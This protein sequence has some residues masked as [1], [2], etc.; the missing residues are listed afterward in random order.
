MRRTAQLLA[1]LMVVPLWARA[2]DAPS[3]A[4]NP[5]VS[6]SVGLHYGGPLRTSVALGLLIDTNE[7]R[8]ESIEVAS[9]IGQQ[10]Y[11]LFVGMLKMQ[12]Q[13]GSGYAVHAT[14][15]RT[16][17]EPWQASSNTTYVGAE[18]QLMI[19]FGVGGR[20]GYLRRV[21]KQV[22]TEHDGVVSFGVSIGI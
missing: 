12:G 15:L 13:F 2:Q 5:R 16:K 20:V 9:E 22:D 8:N 6:P 1:V 21:S 14:A 17:D 7:R 3:T 10:G 11:G 19:A 4:A 18:A